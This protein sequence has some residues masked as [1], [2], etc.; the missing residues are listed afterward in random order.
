MAKFNRVNYIIRY[1]SGELS[2]NDTLKLFSHLIKTGLAWSLQ[3]HYGRIASALIEDKWL[4]R[5][6]KILKVV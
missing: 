5:Q 3:G 6:G 4:S 2:D 1:E